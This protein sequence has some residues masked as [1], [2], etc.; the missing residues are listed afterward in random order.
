MT[1]ARFSLLLRY[2][3]AKGIFAIDRGTAKPRKDIAKWSDVPE[4]LAYC[5]NELYKP[6]YDVLPEHISHEDAVAVLD[7]YRKV[8]DINDD[9]D[10]W[11]AKMKDICEPLGFTPNVKEYKA[12]PDAYKGHIGDVSTIVRVAVT[13]RTNTPD[14]CEIMKILGVDEINAR[15]DA[16]ISRWK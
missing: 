2:R 10:T 12:N 15:F 16:A 3:D 13:S 8:W 5:Y 1:Q 14:L 9:K 4:Y 7:A 11:F 6:D